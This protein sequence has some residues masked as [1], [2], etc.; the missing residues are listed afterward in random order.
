MIIRPIILHCTG[1]AK[2]MGTVTSMCYIHLKILRDVAVPQVRTKANFDE[3]YSRQDE[4]PPLNARTAREYLHQPYPQRWFGRRGSL[5][6]PSRSSCHLTPVDFFSW[7]WSIT[8]FMREIPTQW[9]NRKITFQMHSLKLMVIR[10]Y[11]ILCVIVCAL[12]RYEDLCKVE[13]GHIEHLR[14]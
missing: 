13:G 12:D 10:M 3:L 9:M 5:E 11:V 6:W 14:D 2:S 4:A 8:R 1:W 7:V